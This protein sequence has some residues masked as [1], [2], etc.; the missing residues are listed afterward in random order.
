MYVLLAIVGLAA[1]T[2]AK[3]IILSSGKGGTLI[4]EQNVTASPAIWRQVRNLTINTPT[5]YDIIS[6]IVIIDNREDKDGE[7]AIVEGGLEHKNVTIELKSPAVF[8][9]FD[10]EVQVFVKEDDLH[11]VLNS[12]KTIIDH[13]KNAKDLTEFT[14]KNLNNNEVGLKNSTPMTEQHQINEKENQIYQQVRPNRAQKLQE[15]EPLIS[16]PLDIK[17]N[18]HIQEKHPKRFNPMNG[19]EDWQ[20]IL[21]QILSENGSMEHKFTV[22]PI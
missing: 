22:E 13:Q 16:T 10:F 12:Q 15:Q 19:D 17:D 8:R 20:F 11:P 2:V 18:T 1:S 9:S 3:D 4:Y 7:V 6:R 14:P 21:D 5:P